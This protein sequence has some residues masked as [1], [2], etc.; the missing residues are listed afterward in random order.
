MVY[1]I[2]L[3]ATLFIKIV[4]SQVN[5]VLKQIEEGS[6]ETTLS[7]LAISARLYVCVSLALK[8]LWD[9]LTY[10]WIKLLH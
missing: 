2:A 3:R 6:Q 10:F 1:T 5:A 8:R 9:I 4:N 7:P